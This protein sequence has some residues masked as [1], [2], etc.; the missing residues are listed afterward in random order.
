MNISPWMTSDGELRFP[1]RLLGQV[2][3]LREEALLMQQ[4][5][6]TDGLLLAGLQKT[7]RPLLQQ[8]DGRELTVSAAQVNTY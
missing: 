7:I 8:K 6:Q 2:E 5:V 4:E 1:S 3:V